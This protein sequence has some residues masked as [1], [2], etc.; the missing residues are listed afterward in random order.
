MKRVMYRCKW[1]KTE[2]AA[3]KYQKENRGVL[4]KNTP[5]SRTRKDHLYAGMVFG[6][7][8]EVFPYS[9]NWN[10]IVEVEDY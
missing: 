3:K 7:N 1:F 8:P 9:V 2:E 6:F 10:E 4:Y 5:R